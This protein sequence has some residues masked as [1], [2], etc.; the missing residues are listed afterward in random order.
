[1]DPWTEVPV[2]YQEDFFFKGATM[3]MAVGIWL[4]MLSLS[5]VML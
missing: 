1:M 2:G 4:K 3:H 5:D